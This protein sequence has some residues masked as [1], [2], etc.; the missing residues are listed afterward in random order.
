MQQQAEGVISQVGVASLY[1]LE[2]LLTY[3]DE[4]EERVRTEGEARERTKFKTERR[5]LEDYRRMGP[6]KG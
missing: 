3:L 2:H 6:L 1:F 5:E 4:S